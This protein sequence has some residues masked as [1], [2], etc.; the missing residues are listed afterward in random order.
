MGRRTARYGTLMP[1]WWAVDKSR[2]N[3]LDSPMGCSTEINP[4][5][6][7]ESQNAVPKWLMSMEV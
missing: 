1:S 2:M 6:I 4:R 7:P 5:L 3:A